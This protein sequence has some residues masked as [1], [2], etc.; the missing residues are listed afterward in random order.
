VS[1]AS[2]SQLAADL[3]RLHI[4]LS[5][6]DGDPDEVD[7]PRF[8]AAIQQRLRSDP[9]QVRQLKRIAREVS[10]LMAD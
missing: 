9:T 10:I 8:K 7:D 2:L 3:S 5:L 4:L 6:S 1:E